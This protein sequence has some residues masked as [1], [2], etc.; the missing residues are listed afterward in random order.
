MMDH[1]WRDLVNHEMTQADIAKRMGSHQP[2]VSDW[3]SGRRLPKRK[4]LI[5]LAQ[6]MDIDLEVLSQYILQKWIAR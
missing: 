5:A 4:N 1:T 3:L 2:A 6:A